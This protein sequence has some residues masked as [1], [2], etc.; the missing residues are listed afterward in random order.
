M[1][2]H[3][4]LS[5][6]VM[7]A[8]A[9][10]LRADEIDWASLPYTDIQTMQA[11]NGAGGPAFS[12][13][14]FPLK[15]RG[16]ILNNPEDMLDSSVPHPAGP[17]D[18]GAMWQMFVQTVDV[19]NTSDF[20]G[21]ALF[22]GQKYGNVPPNL[23]FPGGVP[24]PDPSAHYD[25]AT[26]LSEVDRVNH[27]GTHLLRAGDL[28]EVR[29]R[30]GLFFGGKFNI[31]EDHQTDPD[32][33][34]EIVH[35]GNVGLPTPEPLF[36]SSIWDDGNNQVLFDATRATGGEHYQGDLVRLM[37]VRLKD[38]SPWGVDAKATVVDAFGH[39]FRLHLGLN[40]GFASLPTPFGAF[41]I[42]GVF[43]QEAGA[44]GPFTKGYE[45]WAMDADEFRLSGDANHDDS[46]DGADYTIWAD[47]FKLNG[48]FEQGD[49]NA[50]G[51][52]DG[53]D[54]T[55]WADNFISPAT[56][57]IPVPEPATWLT[58]FVGVAALPWFVNRKRRA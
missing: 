37:N 42:V 9:L 3:L 19:N 22:M 43:N 52:I 46:V 29:A 24:T 49:F 50:D 41:D 31:N 58:L 47:N 23:T 35:L 2:R 13:G 20:G 25:D 12:G 10:P 32:F 34:F 18:L 56:A 55:I 14:A 16:V 30:A 45:V 39:E 5:F 8:L 21:V 26:W 57:A 40:S 28:I 6:A 4:P 1:T 44:G 11:V 17:F 54:Y 33:N 53:A 48:D 38:G 36:L 15:V 51:K 27:S 7:L